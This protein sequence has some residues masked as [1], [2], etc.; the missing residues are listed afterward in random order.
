MLESEVE[1]HLQTLV[2]NKN[3]LAIKWVPLG[4]RG[5]PDRIVVFPDRPAAFVELKRPGAVP[6]GQQILRHEELTTKGFQVFTCASKSEVEEVVE[7]ICSTRLPRS[8][9]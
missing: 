1:Y 3:G 4:K 6:R 8:G 9:D 7:T 5:W 2:D